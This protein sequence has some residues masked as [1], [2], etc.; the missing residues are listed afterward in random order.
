LWQPAQAL[1]IGE[2]NQTASTGVPIDAV[3]LQFDIEPVAE[4]VREPVAA[5]AA[6]SAWSA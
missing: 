4:Q 1:G 3:A 2:I 6:R 5:V